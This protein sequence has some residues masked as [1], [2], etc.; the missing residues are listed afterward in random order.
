MTTYK[1]LDCIKYRLTA[2][3]RSLLHNTKAFRVYKQSP[4]GYEYLGVVRG[5]N[6]ISDRTLLKH[7]IRRQ[8]NGKVES[9]T[10]N[11]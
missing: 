8:G 2:Y 4:D 11:I 3:Q 1:H 9:E 7:F 10:A 6:T 5:L